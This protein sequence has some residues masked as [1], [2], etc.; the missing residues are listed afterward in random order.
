MIK[1]KENFYKITKNMR[2][3]FLT[4]EFLKLNITPGKAIDLGCGAGRDTVA[5]IKNNWEVLS[6]D[7]EN[8]ENIIKENLTNEQLN[9]FKFKIQNFENLNIPETD[10][11]IANNSISFCNKELFN[12]LWNTIDKNIKSGGYF[13]GNFFGEK[14][15]WAENKKEMAFFTK[16]NVLELFSKYK[17][18]NFKEIEKHDKTAF[19]IMKYWHIFEIIAEKY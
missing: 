3:N 4:I 19:G 16:A 13:V 5:L 11:V 1:N 14:D 10:L 17:I 9:N 15:D 7:K 12:N 6:I 8:V 18:I 2:P